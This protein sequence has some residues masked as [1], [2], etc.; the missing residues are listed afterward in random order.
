MKCH[1]LVLWAA[2]LTWATMVGGSTSP[3][4]GYNLRMTQEEREKVLDRMHAE[5]VGVE[6]PCVPP[7]N[8]PIN[9]V[10]PMMPNAFSTRVEVAFQED[11]RKKVI[12][13][14][15]SFD[16]ILN[17]GV[18][19]Y[20]LKKICKAQTI[21]GLKE[22]MRFLFGLGEK[23]G[24]G[25]Y[26]G[27]VG[28]M[29]WAYQYQ[30]QY[31][32]T[33]DCRGMICDKFDICISNPNGG[34]VHIVYYWSSTDWHVASDE[35]PVPV[36][37][38]ITSD[39]KMSPLVTRRV[40]QRFDFY[41]FM[42]E[43][44][45]SPEELAPPPDVYC[46][47]RKTSEEPP[48]VPLYFSYSSEAVVGF[49]FSFP[50]GDN[51][52]VNIQFTSIITQSES[53]DWE[54]KIALA[55]YI[56]WYIFGDEYRYD[57]LTRRIQDFNQDLEY[58]I[59]TNLDKQCRYGPMDN[60]TDGGNI[61]INKDGSIGLMPPW[62]FKDLDEPMQYNG[63]H[64]TRGLLSDVWVG[65]K[66]IP[67][68]IFEEDFV[69]YY[70]SPFVSDDESVE[71]LSRE[72]KWH[73]RKNR[74]RDM[75]ESIKEELKSSKKSNSLGNGNDAPSLQSLDKVPIRMERYLNIM[76]GFPHLIY[77]MFDYQ[78]EP[79]L[80][81]TFD[82][83][84][85]YNVSQK[86]DFIVDLPGNT[87]VKVTNLRDKLLY[88]SQHAMAL[89]GILSPL[90][91]NRMVLE[92]RQDSIRL[93]FT[94]L[95]IALAAASATGA[96]KENNMNTAVNLIRNAINTNELVITV[97][98]VKPPEGIEGPLFVTVV[99]IAGSM[100]EVHRGE[101]NDYSYTLDKG[102]HS[103]DMAG[104]AI[105]MLMVGALVGVIINMVIQRGNAT[106]GGLPRVSMARKNRPTSDNTIAINGN[107]TGSEI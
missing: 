35:P 84:P 101:N 28:V 57:H 60:N 52:T 74:R 105:G 9:P 97:E 93:L 33:Q 95:D 81:H 103:G 56:P 83:S 102:Y 92:E 80:T 25:G 79:P 61:I 73:L 46:M 71:N 107:L 54:A 63:I 6:P 36:A 8:T 15:E 69:W 106:P 43:F 85:C 34:T 64:V 39:A 23:I 30:Y 45:P 3:G 31:L 4:E 66:K 32:G 58:Y 59:E 22:E 38:E 94:V 55:D 67:K 29:N 99:P 78:S 65:M 18:L 42:R 41:E 70:A 1:C 40:M 20:E 62:L 96:F 14:Y 17:S 19:S 87:L 26:Y 53:Y 24:D 49:E 88:S 86:R 75:R 2:V 48:E 10:M 100:Q 5:M 89:M 11:N 98:L 44:R 51:D 77:N 82:I 37:V 7:H 27:T 68:T 50:V 104:L 12:F 72:L 13:G 47:N 76:A 16:N 21:L 91:I 90:R